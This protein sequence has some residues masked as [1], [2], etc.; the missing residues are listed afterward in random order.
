MNILAFLKTHHVIALSGSKI[1]FRILCCN[2]PHEIN[3]SNIQVVFYYN[4]TI[5]TNCKML[6]YVLFLAIWCIKTVHSNNR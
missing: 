3:L 1:L 6:S 2:I 5:I 4:K